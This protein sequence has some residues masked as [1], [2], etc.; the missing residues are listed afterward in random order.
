MCNAYKP[1]K[2]S[3]PVPT[4]LHEMQSLYSHCFPSSGG[5]EVG[6]SGE[7]VDKGDDLDARGGPDILVRAESDGSAKITLYTGTL[8]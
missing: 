5:V 1:V 4:T 8:G 7:G 2:P 6:G 3:A